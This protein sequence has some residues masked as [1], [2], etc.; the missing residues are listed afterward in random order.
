MYPRSFQY[1]IAIEIIHIFVDNKMFLKL[2]HF[3]NNK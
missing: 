2:I 1:D 3:N